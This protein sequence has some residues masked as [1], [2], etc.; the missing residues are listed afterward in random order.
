[1]DTRTLLINILVPPLLLGVVAAC[2]A[3]YR[4][5]QNPNL[6]QIN[7]ITNLSHFAPTT[8]SVEI[9][10]FTGAA[11]GSLYIADSSLREDLVSAQADRTISFHLI[12]TDVGNGTAYSWFESAEAGTVQSNAYAQPQAIVSV[13]SATCS[14][15]WFPRDSVF[16]LPPDMTFAPPR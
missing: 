15:W 3:M 4:Y 1:M 7:H 8:C 12:V 11:K 14:P 2:Y 5:G 16:E 10:D 13:G 6:Y 9:N